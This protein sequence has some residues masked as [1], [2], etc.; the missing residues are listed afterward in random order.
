MQQAFNHLLERRFSFLKEKKLLVAVSGGVDSMTLVQLLLIHACDISIAH[1][2]FGLRGDASD[3]D[4]AFVTSFAKEH[5]IPCF[6]KRFDTISYKKEHKLSTQEAARALRYQWFDALRKA[7]GFDFVLTAHH[8]DDSLETFLMNLSRGTGLDGLL[9]I[10]EQNEYIVR[11]MLRFSKAEIIDFAKTHHLKWREDSSNQTDDYLRN[12]IR[13][14]I[15]PHLKSVHPTFENNFLNTLDKLGL[16]TQLLETEVEKFK[17]QHFHTLQKHIEIPVKNLLKLNPLPLFLYRLFKPYGFKDF[18]TLQHLL[19]AQTGKVVLSETHQLTKNRGVLI[20]TKREEEALKLAFTIDEHM[21]AINDPICLKINYNPSKCEKGENT[22]IIDK[23]TIKFP[24]ILRKWQK[25][26]YFYP[27]G[28]QGKKKLSKYFKDEKLSLP[29]KENIWL[30]CNEGQIVWV[31]G[32]R[33]DRRFAA[34]ENLNH[35]IQITYE[36]A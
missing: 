27:T 33:A 34:N 16:H 18:E 28:M 13:H 32:M 20:L 24:L 35:V 15:I 19:Q 11:P 1:V 9:G 31:V 12:K 2:N 3:Q 30:L 14:Q 22:I 4:E 25:G 36:P 6:S 29:E 17:N 5:H 23:K 21:T 26:D 10:P 7:H 8:L